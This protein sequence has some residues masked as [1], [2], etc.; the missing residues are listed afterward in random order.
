MIKDI[1][2]NYFYYMW[3]NNK[4]D[5]GKF[6][7]LLKNKYSY[8]NS[9]EELNKR[10]LDKFNLSFVKKYYNL[11]KD[12]VVFDINNLTEEKLKEI[13]L[14]KFKEIYLNNQDIVEFF[15]TKNLLMYEVWVND[16]K[17]PNLVLVPDYKSKGENNLTFFVVDFYL[18]GENLP[19]DY[20]NRDPKL[21][22]N[23]K[24]IDKSKSVTIKK[25]TK[26]EILNLYKYLPSIITTDKA[27]V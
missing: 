9:V 12:K 3:K 2:D 17:I 16:D 20:K 24:Y 4:E 13:N 19:L 22:M 10:F 25:A 1:N 23:I 21:L 5:A 8:I 14:E 15:K 26:Q 11:F 6:E 27:D 18:L 7:Y